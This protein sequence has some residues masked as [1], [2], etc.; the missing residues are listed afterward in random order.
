MGRMHIY[1]VSGL[2]VASDLVLP[3]LIPIGP[4]GAADVVVRESEVPETLDGATL[5]GPRWQIGEDRFVIDLP[6]IIRMMMIDGR[7]LLYRVADG[8]DRREAAIFVTGT[9]FG[10]LLHQRRTI[11]LH[12][13]AVRVGDRAVLFCGPSGAGKSTLAASLCEAGHD[14]VADDFCAIDLPDMAVPMVHPDGRHL[15]LWEDA[16]EGLSLVHRKGGAVRDAIRKFYVEPRTATGRALPI[17]AIYALREARPPWTP[18][19][20][21][22]NMVDAALIVRRNAYRP[23][24]VR[25]MRQAPLYFEAAARLAGSIGVYSLARK[26]DFAGLPALIAALEA[27]WRSPGMLERAA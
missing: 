24:L 13:S 6:G 15:K 23:L 5:V 16:T 9:G 11:L 12:A 21:V 8:A 27:H 7:E 22:P 3:S 25:Q 2:R 20:H 4:L 19:I 26:L 1:R 10:I 17:A 14:L 18:G